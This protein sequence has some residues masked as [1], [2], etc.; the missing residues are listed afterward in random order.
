MPASF[1]ESRLAPYVFFLDRNLGSSVIETA[2]RQAHIKVEVHDDHFA[3]N[4]LDEEWLTFVGRHGWV[5]LTKDEKIRY[6]P[7]EIRALMQAGVPTFVVIA[8]NRTLPTVANIIVRA[9]PAIARFLEKYTPPF[10]AKIEADSRVS[11]I[12]EK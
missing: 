6:R 8:K 2:L 1:D 3:Q 9:L 5:V 7:N 11:M 10:I 4:A 12:R